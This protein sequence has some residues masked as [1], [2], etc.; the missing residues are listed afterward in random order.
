MTPIKK[1]PGTN[2]SFSNGPASKQEMS[3]T[4]SDVNDGG[5]DGAASG[6]DSGYDLDPHIDL[7]TTTSFKN[8]PLVE[9]T[10]VRAYLEL[11]SEQSIAEHGKFG[12]RDANSSEPVAG[13]QKTPPRPKKRKNSAVSAIE[14]VDVVKREDVTPQKSPVAS[15][16]QNKAP[17]GNNR[18]KPEPTS[19]TADEEPVPDPAF[20]EK[21]NAAL[22]HS[23][24]V[25]AYLVRCNAGGNKKDGDAGKVGSNSGATKTTIPQTK[26]EAERLGAINKLAYERKPKTKGTDPTEDLDAL[27]KRLKQKGMYRVPN[28]GRGNCLFLA[29]RQQADLE[30]PEVLDHWNIKSDTEL[31]V[32]LCTWLSH[33]PMYSRYEQKLNEDG[34]PFHDENGDIA[35]LE[36]KNNFADLLSAGDGYHADDTDAWENYLAA[37]SEADKLWGNEVFLKAFVGAF[38]VGVRVFHGHYIHGGNMANTDDFIWDH[39]P[40]CQEGRGPT[41]GCVTLMLCHHFENHFEAVRDMH[42]SGKVRYMD[43][44]GKM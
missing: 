30:C 10:D 11:L 35:Y 43:A 18:V 24:K 12:S 39:M 17:K 9:S 19:H 15:K 26:A 6:S 5:L 44:S 21:L 27:S 40:S 29:L 41:R 14:V 16:P 31:R 4:G 32:H 38:G 8:L 3:S 2:D 13:V 23:R 34:T 28:A 22:E 7:G 33:N 1:E 37:M 25:K 42:S 36:N 20:Q